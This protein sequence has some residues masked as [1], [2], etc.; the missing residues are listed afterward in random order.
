MKPQPPP[1]VP[2]KTEAEKFSNA[3]KMV[4]AVPAEAITQEKNRL[5][6]IKVRKKLAKERSRQRPLSR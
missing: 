4:L 3:V 6:R 5:K 1:H 2:G